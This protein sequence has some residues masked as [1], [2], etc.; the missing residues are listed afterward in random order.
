MS[1]L[2][3]LLLALHVAVH[4][5]SFKVDELV[6]QFALDVDNFRETIIALRKTEGVVL[7]I[8]GEETTWED[9]LLASASA[10]DKAASEDRLLSSKGLENVLFFSF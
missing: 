10:R 9:L 7:E 3:S 8:Y 2:P 6:D 1:L 4:G 5:L